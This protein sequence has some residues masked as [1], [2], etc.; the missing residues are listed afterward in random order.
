MAS[1]PSDKVP[2]TSLGPQQLVRVRDQLAADVDDLVDSHAQLGRFAARSS[3]AARAVETLADSKTG[4][5]MLG[6][7]LQTRLPDASCHQMQCTVWYSLITLS[8][9]RTC[10]SLLS[11]HHSATQQLC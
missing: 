7:S 8:T 10:L 11:C 6:G 1:Q 3:S 9:V 4:M 2:I 5:V